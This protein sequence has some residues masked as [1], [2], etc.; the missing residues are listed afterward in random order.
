MMVAYLIPIRYAT[1]LLCSCLYRVVRKD[2]VYMK[3]IDKRILLSVAQWIGD[4][5][6][7]VVQKIRELS[8]TEEN[9]LLI[10]R[11]LDRVTGQ[12]IQARMQKVEA[13]LTLMEWFIT[14]ED[15]HWQCAYCQS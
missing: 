10:I 14:L 3:Q 2:N 12:V 11:E 7:R 9:Y 13:T 8:E 4:G 5:N 6:R 15:F 1:G